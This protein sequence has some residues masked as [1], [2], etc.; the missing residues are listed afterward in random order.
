MYHAVYS[1]VYTMEGKI[2]IGLFEVFLC[3]FCGPA[4]FVREPVGFPETFPGQGGHWRVVLP[5]V[6][7]HAYNPVFLL[8][9]LFLHYESL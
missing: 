2:H 4:L 3:R 7:P 5:S 8:L 1:I 6:L 9:R